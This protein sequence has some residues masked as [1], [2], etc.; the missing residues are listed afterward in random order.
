MSN[1]QRSRRSRDT[2]AFGK[3]IA[4]RRKA[5]GLSQAAAAEVAARY[6]EGESF[7]AQRWKEI[8]RGIGRARRDRVRAM[9]RAVDPRD[10]GTRLD[11]AYKMLGYQ[12]DETV[13]GLAGSDAEPGRRLAQ[14]LY[15]VKQIILGAE[16]ETVAHAL[17][18]IVLRDYWRD[19]PRPTTRPVAAVVAAERT[20]ELFL[21]L[22]PWV[23]DDQLRALAEAIV[24]GLKLVERAKREQSGCLLTWR[25]FADA[26]GLIVKLKGG[27]D[28]LSAYL[29]GRLR[30]DTHK[31]MNDYKG[32]RP[33]AQLL[34]ALRGDLN[35]VLRG[36]TIFEP[37]RFGQ[38]R[39]PPESLLSLEARSSSADLIRSNRLL[40]EDAYPDEIVRRADALPRSERRPI[41][42]STTLR[43]ST[44]G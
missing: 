10:D 25:D 43:C 14:T 34:N 38:V 23:G 28:A 12:P 32:G 5:A 2:V 1:N 3:W 9:V 24:K 20:H 16:D 8:E 7:S 27:S 36:G 44:T 15:A 17:F 29:H 22:L 39:V 41:S 30:N 31:L 18:A 6:I 33:K 19:R 40:L 37:E 21:D 4:G 42:C 26:Q 35:E 13:A 11:R